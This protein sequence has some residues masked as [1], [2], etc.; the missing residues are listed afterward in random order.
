MCT[1]VGD[2]P[3]ALNPLGEAQPVDATFG[4]PKLCLVGNVYE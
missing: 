4:D 3:A 1:R 2:K